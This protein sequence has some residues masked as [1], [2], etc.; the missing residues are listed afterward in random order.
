MNAA[1]LRALDAS[2]R[3]LA[4]GA[5]FARSE[6]RLRRE[7][8]ASPEPF[9]WTVLPLAGLGVPAAIKSCWMFVL[10]RGTWSGAHYHPNSIQHM[11]VV[12]GR[13]IARIGGIERRIASRGRALADRC[14]VIGKGTPHEFLPEGRDMTVV[15]FHTCTA[16]ELEEIAAG[17]G[18]A[19]HYRPAGAA[20]AAPT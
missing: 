6:Q 20:P 8:A 9:V 16:E 18:A 17:T 19:R 10:R 14:C 3:R 4:R 15:S 1:R 2:A 12:H 11:V 7:L 13:G 5:A